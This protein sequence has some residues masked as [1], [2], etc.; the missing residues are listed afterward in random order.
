MILNESG[1]ERKDLEKTERC[2]FILYDMYT[3]IDS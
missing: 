3:Y 1:E 2:L